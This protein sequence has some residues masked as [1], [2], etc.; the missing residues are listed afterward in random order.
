MKMEVEG[1]G[2][3]EE[4]DIVGFDPGE[5]LVHVFS[6]TNTAA[7]H[8]HKGKWSDNNTLNLVNEGLQEGKNYKEQI[9]IKFRNPKEF[10]IHEV[11]T[12]DGQVTSTMDVILRK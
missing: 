6:V 9:T 7:T 12:L 2:N 10:S 3:Y 4:V 11:D 5:G 1:M 8:D